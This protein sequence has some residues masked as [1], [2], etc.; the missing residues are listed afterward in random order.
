MQ[1]QQYD[2]LYGLNGGLENNRYNSYGFE[3]NGRAN[4]TANSTSGSTALYHHNGSRY[5]LGLPARGNG[6]DSK[7][8][9]LHGPKHKRGDMDRECTWISSLLFART[10]ASYAYQLIDLLV[11][12]W[13]IYRARFQPCVRISMD[14]D[15]CKRNW[16]RVCLSIVI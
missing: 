2:S 14:V 3:S 15:I 13:R 11:H 1:Q 12:V 7:M 5:G 8:N 4:S 16:K 9:G 10:K 6:A